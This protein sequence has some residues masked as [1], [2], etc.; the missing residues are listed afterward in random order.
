MEEGAAEGEGE[1]AKGGG[2]GG[3]GGKQGVE[4]TPRPSSKPG[5]LTFLRKQRATT[6]A[7]AA[8]ISASSCFFPFYRFRVSFVIVFIC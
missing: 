4:G 6:L 1:G 3:V 5:P 8:E 7:R 2:E